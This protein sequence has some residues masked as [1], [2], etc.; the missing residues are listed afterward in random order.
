M[1]EG[2]KKESCKMRSLKD[3]EESERSK[4]NLPLSCPERMLS[5]M[6]RWECVFFIN[7]VWGNS[8]RCVRGYA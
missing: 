1:P 4:K 5:N 8:G 7:S 3:G 2:V 6:Q